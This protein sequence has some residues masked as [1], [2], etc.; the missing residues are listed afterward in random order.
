M[1][2]LQLNCLFLTHYTAIIIIIIIIIIIVSGTMVC[3]HS[4]PFNK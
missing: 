2:I 4:Q 3:V 1:S